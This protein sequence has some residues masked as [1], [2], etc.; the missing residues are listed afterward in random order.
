MTN[1]HCQRVGSVL[2]FDDSLKAREC[3]DHHLHLLFFG[4]A[5]A[6]H[7][8]L[9][10]ERR[11]L[12]QG[13][14]GLC[15]G[16]QRDRLTFMFVPS[17]TN[18]I[19]SAIITEN[20]PHGPGRDAKEHANIMGKLQFALVGGT[21]LG[22]TNS[23]AEFSPPSG[24]ANPSGNFFMTSAYDDPTANICVGTFVT[25]EMLAFGSPG[26]NPPPVTATNTTATSANSVR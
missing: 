12:A 13:N 1:R 3:P 11:I 25:K 19:G 21:A 14:M 5:V 20:G 10:R 9:D 2:G 8:D 6:H 24:G 15:D 22:S 7:A 4:P 17:L 16:K 23:G 18:A 26:T